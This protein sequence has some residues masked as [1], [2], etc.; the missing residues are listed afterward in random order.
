M[1][2]TIFLTIHQEGGHSKG[3]GAFGA[4]PFVVESA[5]VDGEKYGVIY[6][7]I[8]P[9]SCDTNSSVQM[10]VCPGHVSPGLADS[11]K[12]SLHYKSRSISVGVPETYE[13]C[14]G[15]L[16]DLLQIALQS[17]RRS[18]NYIELHRLSSVRCSRIT[19]TVKC[20]RNHEI[21]KL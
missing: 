13:M 20:Q 18:R 2:D 12:Y 4:R 15:H 11:Y 7:A 6:G 9:T 1:Y 17:F 8:Y 3:A 21:A 16:S 5:V 19:S 10:R 14:V